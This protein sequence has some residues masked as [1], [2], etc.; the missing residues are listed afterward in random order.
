MIKMDN[1]YV[2][3]VERAQLGDKQGLELLTELAEERLREDVGRITL[4][5]DLT[6]D[7]VQETLLEMLKKLGELKTADRFWKWLTQIA[8]NKINHHHRKEKRHETALVAHGG[9]DADEFRQ[10]QDVL[11]GLI[12]QEFQQIVIAAMRRLKSRQRSVLTLRCYRDM[13]YSDIA[14]VMGCSEFAA[15]M[16]FHRAKK[17]LKRQLARHGYGKG[18][19][20]PALVLFGKLTASS[21]SD[22]AQISVCA[23]VTEESGLVGLVGLVNGKAAIVCLTSIVVI[24]A[25]VMAVSTLIP[26]KP[27]A[28]SLQDSGPSVQAAGPRAQTET[29][30][31]K[32]WTYFPEGVNGPMMMR[33][34]A[35]TPY[36]IYKWLVVQDEE[37]NYYYDGQDV[38]INNHR[39]WS[40]KTLRLATDNRVLSRFLTQ[41]DSLESPFDAVSASGRDVLVSATENEDGGLIHPTVEHRGSVLDEPFF[42]SDWPDDAEILD[43]RDAMHKRGWTYF[44]IAGQIQGQTVTGYGRIPF[45]YAAF[46]KNRPYLLLRVGNLSVVDTPRSASILDKRTNQAYRVPSGTFFQGL[47][48]PWM[49]LHTLDCVRRDAAK[50]RIPFETEISKDQL[51][52][53]V[54]VTMR[55]LTLDYTIDLDN[56]LLIRIDMS[57][58][59][60]SIGVLEFSHLQDLSNTGIMKTPSAS[61]SG[62]LRR[63]LAGPVWLE[64]LASMTFFQD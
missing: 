64:H 62:T 14:E 55:D 47:G 17:S 34:Q 53:K 44:R 50:M 9:R 24:L 22:A 61:P 38:H 60:K 40:E 12:G 18:L 46:K 16:L 51:S 54:T 36:H 45:V 33:S 52:A 29:Q 43:Y 20:M 41:M 25:V 56:D 26:E 58:G 5:L 2:K 4:N 1:D 49:G 57:Q 37:N 8:F 31:T 23:A 63:D 28:G 48:R 30:P 32:H 10:G 19:L 39:S 13:A 27:T 21:E 3:L 35:D 42:L 11:A 7:I 6:Q 15:M 59:D